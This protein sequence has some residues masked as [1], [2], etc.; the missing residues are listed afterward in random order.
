[1]EAV[2]A[3]HGFAGTG[4]SWQEVAPEAIAPDLP[5]HGEASDVAP[6]VAACVER[7]LAAAPD[8]FVLAGYS[9]GGRVALHVALAAPERVSRLVLVSATGGIEDT[10]ER[11][12]RRVADETLA[13]RF[14]S[15]T[16]EEIAEEWVNQPLFA[17]DPPEARDRQHQD[18]L[19]NTPLGLAAALRGIGTGVM[20]P[21]W[22]RLGA[23]SMPAV[24]M[25][26]ER[27]AKYVALG[28]WLAAELPR[29]EL[30]IVPGAGHGLLREAPEA[31]RAALGL[32][33]LRG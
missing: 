8:R 31:V 33:P 19:R 9:M 25:A 11:G 6:T 30:V 23:L 27:D 18:V 22:T 5:G 17:A 20:E 24:V 4:R 28:E 14:R 7:V 2:V 21:L 15:L 1:M 12:E 10:R 32:P 13:R 16:I 3:L 29:S 26:G